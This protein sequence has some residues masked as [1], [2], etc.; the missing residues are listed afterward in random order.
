MI[1]SVAEEYEADSK[2]WNA[3]GLSKYIVI[4][5]IKVKTNFFR[6]NLG[7]IF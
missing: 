2:I 6:D 7:I 1:K 4:I 3:D 5:N